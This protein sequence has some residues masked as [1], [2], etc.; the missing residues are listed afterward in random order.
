LK[1]KNIKMTDLNDN[2]NLRTSF[3]SLTVSHPTDADK[4]KELSKEERRKLRNKDIPNILLILFLYVIQ[5][6]PIGMTISIPLILSS[7]DVS[8]TEQGIFS[9]ALWPISMRILWAPIVDSI[10]FRR[11]GRRKS[12]LV[13]T[14]IV[15]GLIALFSASFVN[16]LLDENK[17]KET[18]DIY[19]LT[20]I[21]AVFVTLIITHDMIMDGW[22]ISLLLKY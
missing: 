8:Y 19:A 6:I 21:F 17:P 5:G 9:F 13:P 4:D 3:K 20:A 10:Y 16:N 22:A 15:F 2:E 1:N 7:R 18:K 12:W 14:E 11:L